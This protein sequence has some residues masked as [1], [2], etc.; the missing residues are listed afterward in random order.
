NRHAHGITSAS[1]FL[2][3]PCRSAPAPDP[4][5]AVGGVG[6]EGATSE[7]S[8]RCCGIRR[9]PASWESGSGAGFSSHSTSD[10][11]HQDYPPPQGRKRGNILATNADDETFPDALHA[12]GT[13]VNTGQNGVR[14]AVPGE[15]NPL[16]RR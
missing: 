5:P 10:P 3:L 8:E 11:R 1:S 14:H 7:Q 13:P 4:L 2:I 9:D 6:T 12:R 15:P 16:S